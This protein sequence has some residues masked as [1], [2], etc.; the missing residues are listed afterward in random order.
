MLT[1][2]T[3]EPS[4]MAAAEALGRGEIVAVPTETVYG[5]AV[6][7]DNPDA[8][9][10]LFALKR[11]PNNVPLPVALGD[12][13]WLERHTPPVPALAVAL[14]DSFWPGPLTLVVRA[15]TD[16]FVHVQDE[17]GTVALRVPDHP[18]TRALLKAYDR[19]LALTSANLHGEP[20][21][22]NATKV[23]SQFSTG[24]AVVLDGGDATLGTPSTIV[25]L[26]D[27]ESA[28]I[29]RQGA[30][31]EEALAQVISGFGAVIR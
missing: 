4:V 1:K 23:R 13:S 11:R 3:M 19:P 24:I 15:A 26:L 10:R 5:L 16:R 17:R 18:L 28:Q 30:L 22:T 31:R 20:D 25:E 2:D 27:S 29:L 12:A 8:I 7:A 9:R 21:P 14:A 6:D